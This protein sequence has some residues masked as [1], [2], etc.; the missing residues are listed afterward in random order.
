MICR[1]ALVGTFFLSVV[2]CHVLL[3]KIKHPTLGESFSYLKVHKKKSILVKKSDNTKPALD[4]EVSDC[5]GWIV[6]IFP[7]NLKMHP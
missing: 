7:I 5:V 2:Y 3:L 4:S 1:L 6:F